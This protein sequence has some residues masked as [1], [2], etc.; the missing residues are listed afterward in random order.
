LAGVL[1]AAAIP[2][3]LVRQQGAADGLATFALGYAPVLAFAA[4]VTLLAGPPPVASAPA[5]AVSLSALMLPLRNARFRRLAAVFLVNGMAAAVPAT[6]L[7]FFAADVLQRA[8][9][10]PLFLILYFAAGAA[11]MPLWVRLADRAGKVRAWLVAMVLAVAAFVWTWFL[12][13][14][15]AAAFAA[16]CVLSGIAFGADLALPA[17]LLADLIDDDEDDR[18]RPDGAYFGL[19]HLL[20]KLALALAAGVALPMLQWLGYQPGSAAGSGSALSLVYALLPCA[21]KLAAAAMLA[22][23]LTDTRHTAMS[24]K[25]VVK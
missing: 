18:G 8:D 23:T 25:G 9:L 1:C 21:I 15:D 7:L 5:R 14:G 13:A 20:E 22:L 2:E 24:L 17:S 11:G 3:L 16:V 4:G 10:T 6:L 12:G 19:W